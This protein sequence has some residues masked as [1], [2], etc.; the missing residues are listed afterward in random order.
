MTT[1]NQNG[2]R[3]A[4]SMR[5]AGQVRSARRPGRLGST[6]PAR[7][8]SGP[9]AVGP[10]ADDVLSRWIATQAVNLRRH[11]ASLRP[12]TYTEFGTGPAAPS[13]AHIDAVNRFIGEFRD[14]LGDTAAYVDAAAAASVKRPTDANLKLLLGRKEDISRQVFY[15]EGIWDFYFDLFVQR[16]SSFGERLRAVDRIGANCYEDLYLGLGTARPA[17][18]L[19]PFSYAS[20]GFS[21]LTY[22]RGVPLR[23]LQ[24]HP[25]LFPLIVFPQHRLDN[26]WALSS[27]LHEVCHV[28]QD[29]LGLWEIMPK[30]VFERLTRDG[31]IPA[32]IAAIWARW[33]KEIAADL[34]ALVLGGPATVESLM[35]VVGRSRE[36]TVGYAAGSVHPTPVLRV[37][38]NLILLRRLGF[39]SMAAAIDAAWRRLYPK[40]TRADIPAGLLRTFRRAAE[41]TVDTMVFTPRP[42]LAG[43]TFAQLVEFGPSQMALIEQAATRIAKG[44][45]VGS[46]PPRLMISAARRAL[47]Q[48]LTAPQTITDNFYKSLGRL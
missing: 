2:S 14:R 24:R 11:A 1:V 8:P 46:V 27:A 10:K 44:E 19:L 42:Q 15:G 41:L 36:A 6:G 22:R 48:R 7:R 43:K 45:D 47:D 40:I 23:R 35:D 31:G 21:P 32:D 16:L 39:S 34:F 13:H 28:L 9:G 5:W 12:F 4:R 25:N 29:D 17:P 3:Q 38:I 20:P 18:R 26:V 37:P 30:L 33:H